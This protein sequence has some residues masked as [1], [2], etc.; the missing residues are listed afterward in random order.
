M[1]TPTARIGAQRRN[2]DLAQLPPHR[3]PQILQM[4]CELDDTKDLVR[5]LTSTNDDLQTQRLLLLTQLDDVKQSKDFQIDCLREQL[6]QAHFKLRKAERRNRY[7]DD[8][9][10]WKADAKYKKKR[11]V[12][13]TTNSL[14]GF[15][16]YEPDEHKEDI[17]KERRGAQGLVSKSV[18]VV[19]AMMNRFN[20]ELFQ[21]AASISDV[22]ENMGFERASMLSGNR[23]RAERVLGT[24]LV[25]MILPTVP[26]SKDGQVLNPLV[27][28]VVAQAFLA[29]WC[30]SII[31]AWYPK[32]ETFAE[33]L[34]DLSS[35]LK[36]G[37]ESKFP[38]M[39][40][41]KT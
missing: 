15:P 32:Q 37:S 6:D 13:E 21:T 23:E 41:S 12:Q 17:L 9:D 28:Q 5:H 26:R 14:F 2:D 22:V 40:V 29:H 11:K 36:V 25:S 7:V 38:P 35:K 3:S 4:R 16:S 10:R 18:T 39:A 31:E 20:E 30:N 27:V 24:R 34:V 33:F 19:T 8:T 1:A